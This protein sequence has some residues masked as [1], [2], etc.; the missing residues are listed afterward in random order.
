MAKAKNRGRPPSK[1]PVN[2]STALMLSDQDFDLLANAANKL[3]ETPSEIARQIISAIVVDALAGRL[4]P[5]E[6]AKKRLTFRVPEQLLR[7]FRLA[8]GGRA[9]G[10]AQSEYFS[11]YLKRLHGP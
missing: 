5:P 2:G 11:A 6:G 8:A 1:N 3:G 10:S 9:G 4:A 7:E